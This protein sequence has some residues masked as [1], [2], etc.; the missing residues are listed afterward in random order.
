MTGAH[1]HVRLVGGMVIPASF[2]GVTM[3]RLEHGHPHTAGG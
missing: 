3:L 1:S 2:C